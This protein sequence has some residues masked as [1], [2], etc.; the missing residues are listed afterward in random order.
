ML[1]LG[2]FKSETFIKKKTNGIFPLQS[3]TRNVNSSSLLD[4]GLDEA[5]ERMRSHRDR[6]KEDRGLRIGP[7]ENINR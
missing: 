2:H 6:K 5:A 3:R 1:S 7:W 4:L